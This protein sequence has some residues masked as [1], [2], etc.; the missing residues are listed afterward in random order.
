MAS[1]APCRDFA[2]PQFA[3][4]PQIDS[5]SGAIAEAH[6]RRKHETVVA[7]RGLNTR[8][9]PSSPVSVSAPHEQ[10]AM[11][12]K[13]VYSGYVAA[14]HVAYATAPTDPLKLIAADTAE[15]S[16]HAAKVET[17]DDSLP[18]RP[19]SI[20]LLCNT[21]DRNPAVTEA[22]LDAMSVWSKF[23]YDRVNCVVNRVRMTALFGADCAFFM[24]TVGHECSD[25]TVMTS[26]AVRILVRWNNGHNMTSEW[27]DVAH[28]A[29]ATGVSALRELQDTVT[30]IAGVYNA[31][32]PMEVC[33]KPVYMTVT[34][35]VFYH[36]L[37]ATGTEFF[38]MLEGTP[39][40]TLAKGAKELE[41]TGVLV[42]VA[43]KH[44]GPAGVS[45]SSAFHGALL[46]SHDKRDNVVEFALQSDHL[47]LRLPIAS[48]EVAMHI[49]LCAVQAEGMK[50]GKFV[51]LYGPMGIAGK[52]IHSPESWVWVARPAIRPVDFTLF[53]TWAL[54]PCTKQSLIP[55]KKE[56]V[57]AF[58]RFWH[59][60]T[61]I[62]RLMSGATPGMQA[63]LSSDSIDSAAS[64]VRAP[65]PDDVTVPVPSS[66]D[67]FIMTALQ[68]D[69]KSRRTTL[70]DAYAQI[71]SVAGQTAITDNMKQAMADLGVRA[72]LHD[73]FEH[74]QRAIAAVRQSDASTHPPSCVL[75]NLCEVALD[76][77][78]GAKRA[79]T[80]HPNEP[81]CLPPDRVRRILGAC[82][83]KR[84]D[85]LT[86][87]EGRKFD[88]SALQRLIN[89]ATCT[90]LE[91][92]SPVYALGKRPLKSLEGD[93]ADTETF[94]ARVEQAIAM[95]AAFALVATKSVS[96][97]TFLVVSAPKSDE[98][99]IKTI[100]LNGTVRGG[101]MDDMCRVSEPRVIILQKMSAVSVR[102]TATV[103]AC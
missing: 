76:M 39:S 96:A 62:Y 93:G 67:L 52:P 82:G 72:S 58:E 45:D 59:Q 32:V 30:R 8:I 18:A 17:L 85:H 80:R 94:V 36:N 19:V 68:L 99:S 63:C 46:A 25:T 61:N 88:A 102:V 43:P 4:L 23:K 21:V 51:S 56:L 71:M 5:P 64:T 1:T 41:P 49:H 22:F 97:R 86:L 9:L 16:A 69:M 11:W 55:K 92:S 38:N 47:G 14:Q 24:Q 29:G 81:L 54:H 70:G 26:N 2:L 89:D 84:G 28:G 44:L 74:N 65:S 75:M 12:F 13:E 90:K 40:I 7:P 42:R 60:T 91:P 15:L 27:R 20:W 6:Q 83:L 35:Q 10:S 53:D 33:G 100:E 98:V 37:A 66:Q 95:A 103:P 101:L 79:R 3:D 77:A 48:E 34:P 73:M 57:H 31:P 87:E 78:P 50:L